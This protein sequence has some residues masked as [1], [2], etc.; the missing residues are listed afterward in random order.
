MAKPLPDRVEIACKI[1]ALASGDLSRA[2]V[3]AWAVQ[4]LL[5]DDCDVSDEIAWGVIN[6]LGGVDT[7]SV[8][9]PYLYGPLDFD[10]WL[11]TLGATE[12]ADGLPQGLCAYDETP[13]R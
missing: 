9:R 11:E 2:D 1:R 13:R 6:A 12:G 7:P 8:D 5:D 4:L 10:D 3:S